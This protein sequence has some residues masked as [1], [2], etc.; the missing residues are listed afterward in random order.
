MKNIV[1]AICLLIVGYTMQA[2][3]KKNKNAKYTIAVSGN[4]GL[5]KKRIEKAAYGVNG[6]KSA[7]WSA[8]TQQL[9]LVVNEEKTTISDIKKT[10]SKVGHDSEE[11]KATTEAYESLHHCCKYER[12]K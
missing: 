12:E 10:I 7:V 11:E 1:I 5:C 2:Q 9:V 6:V 8:D 3:E 4:C